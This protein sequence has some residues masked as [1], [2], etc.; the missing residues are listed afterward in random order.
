MIFSLRSSDH[1]DKTLAA[2]RQTCDDLK[3][4]QIDDKTRDSEN[5]LISEK[6]LR[7]PIIYLEHFSHDSL[8]L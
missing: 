4:L 7:S 8:L 5:F 1:L 3:M 2:S 6:N